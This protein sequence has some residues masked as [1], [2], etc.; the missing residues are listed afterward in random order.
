MN[1]EKFIKQL[2]LTERQFSGQDE[3]VGSLYL[4]SLTAIPEGFNPT[5]GGSLYLKNKAQH[6]GDIVDDT[7]IN[8][9]FFWK[10]NGKEYAL[11]DRV[12]CEILAKRNHTI[13]GETFCIYSAKKIGKPDTFFIVGN[14]KYY[15]HA[16]S[17][18][19]GVEDVR[20]KIVAEKLK[21]EPINADTMITRAHYRAI[22]GAC[23]LGTESWI[24]ENGLGDKQ[25]MRADELLP[26]LKRTKPYG[27]ER[28]KQL[29]SF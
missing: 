11:I 7:Y 4:G 16:E 18:N 6:I 9:N 17:I 27:F 8:Q 21:H 14:G 26:I 1:K 2:G 15:A 13:D 20:F 19:K 5:V 25:E 24:K 12:F 10:M 22:T 3:I 29:I 28:F 23:D